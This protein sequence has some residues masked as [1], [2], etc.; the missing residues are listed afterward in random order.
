MP[1]TRDVRIRDFVYLD[2]ERL[3]SIVAQVEEGRA[4]PC[5]MPRFVRRIPSGASLLQKRAC[6]SDGST[7]G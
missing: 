1:D 4:T 7:P 5:D 6:L 3:K 2:V